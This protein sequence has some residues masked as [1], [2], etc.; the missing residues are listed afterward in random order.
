MFNKERKQVRKLIKGDLKVYRKLFDKHYDQL[1]GY[2]VNALKSNDLAVAVVEDAFTVL[3]DNRRSL[4][5]DTALG[6]LLLEMVEDKVFE[7]LSS[8][9]ADDKLHEEIWQAIQSTSTTAGEPILDKAQDSMIRVVRNNMLRRQLIHQLAT[10]R[11]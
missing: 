3:W 1:L 6:S 2:A 9:A 11:R 7:V 4:D 8:V 5:P 10:T